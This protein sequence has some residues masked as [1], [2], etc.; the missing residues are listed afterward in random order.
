MGYKSY[1][2]VKVLGSPLS[3]GVIGFSCPKEGAQPNFPQL[4][5]YPTL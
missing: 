3:G 2:F 5:I 1:N 4:K